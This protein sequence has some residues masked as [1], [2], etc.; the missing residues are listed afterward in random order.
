[1]ARLHLITGA[2]LHRAFART[3]WRNLPLTDKLDIWRSAKLLMAERGEQASE[4]A[5]RCI[6]ELS[7]QGD[8]T[9]VTVWSDILAA[10]GSLRAQK[11]PP[12]A[13]TH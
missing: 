6:S 3:G 8:A 11:P 7:V 2:G 9:G 4:H 10:I 13:A 1:M 5:A 12:G